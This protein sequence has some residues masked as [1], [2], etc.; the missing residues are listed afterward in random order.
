M[1]NHHKILY[2][3]YV[4]IILTLFKPALPVLLMDTSPS[5][6]ANLTISAAFSW[7]IFLSIGDSNNVETV[8]LGSLHGDSN[9]DETDFLGSLHGDSN[10]D[11]TVF[12]GSLHGGS[13]NDETVFLGSLHGGSNNEETVFLGSLH[14]DSNNDETVFLGSLHLFTSCLL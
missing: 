9:N 4:I 12:L 8:F 6:F 11:E 14:G 5:L 3:S 10:N 1:R 2:K 13:N 7:S